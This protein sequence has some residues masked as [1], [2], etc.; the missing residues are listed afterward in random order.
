M[1]HTKELLTKLAVF[2]AGGYLEL[3]QVVSGRRRAAEIIGW[4]AIL[5]S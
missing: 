5:G 1:F 2:G 4:Y 3:E